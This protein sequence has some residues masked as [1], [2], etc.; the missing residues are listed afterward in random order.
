MEDNFEKI[1]SFT[2]E[3]II[4]MLALKLDRTSP[5][6]DRI[7]IAKVPGGQAHVFIH[8]RPQPANDDQPV[9]VG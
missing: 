2:L 4:G 3:G 9:E 8:E 5:E 6:W 1:D 7:E